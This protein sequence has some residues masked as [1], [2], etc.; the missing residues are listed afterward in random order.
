MCLCA[1]MQSRVYIHALKPKNSCVWQRAAG[2][3]DSGMNL[4]HPIQWVTCPLLTEPPHQPLVFWRTGSI[5][6]RNVFPFLVLCTRKWTQ[7]LPLS[8]ISLQP[9]QTTLG[10]KSFV[11]FPT[12][13]T[14]PITVF[15]TL[16]L[17]MT[18]L[19]AL[20]WALAAQE[21]LFSCIFGFWVFHTESWCG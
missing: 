18:S 3:S 11:C 10:S 12:I 16:K 8:W 17:L 14:H 9:K 7:D 13:P 20:L 2:V 5:R 4:G 1:W 19:L 15:G 6:Y 21:W